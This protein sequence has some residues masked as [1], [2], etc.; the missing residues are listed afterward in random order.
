MDSNVY[1]SNDLNESFFGTQPWEEHPSFSDICAPLNFQE[2]E[3]W[4]ARYQSCTRN[5]NFQ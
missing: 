1:I 5:E 2:E 3:R 4:G